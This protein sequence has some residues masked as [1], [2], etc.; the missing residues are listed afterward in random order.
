[1]CNA[2]TPI[3]FFLISTR[4]GSCELGLDTE[5]AQQ[6]LCYRPTQADT[7]LIAQTGSVLPYFNREAQRPRI[8]IISFSSSFFNCIQYCKR[9]ITASFS[10]SLFQ[11]EPSE[12]LRQTLH[13]QFFLISTCCILFFFPL[14]YL[15]VL[16]YFNN[17]LPSFLVPY[18]AFSSSLF[19]RI[20][21]NESELCMPTFSS[22]LFQLLRKGKIPKYSVLSVLPYFNMLS[23]RCGIIC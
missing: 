1:M 20:Y 6:C 16:P 10:S 12:C 22:S 18:V 9:L 8:T 14:I 15:S 7:E 3:Q 13:F 11:Q 4:P 17:C 23:M 21:L 19:Q 2:Q 5:S